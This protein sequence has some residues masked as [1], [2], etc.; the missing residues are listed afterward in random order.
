VSHA[1]EILRSVAARAAGR[2]G[3]HGHAAPPA[4]AEPA[5]GLQQATFGG[6]C[7][8]CTEA[9]FRRLKGVRAVTS[10]YSGGTEKNPTYALICSGTT[11]HAEVIQ[12]EFDPAQISYT[13]LLEVFWR[14]HDPTTRDRQ[15]ADV[16]PQYRSVIFYHT[17]EQKRT[18]EDL[19]RQLDAKGIFAA[20]IVTEVAPFSVFYP[21]ENYHQDYY[22]VNGRQPYCQVVIRPKL[23]KF[24]QVFKSKLK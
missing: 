12:V 22:A 23:E 24:E 6:G 15:G 17:Q 16:G 5:G 9:V 1:L 11:R 4:S 20:P 3:G 19:R 14:T 21:A 13:E 18:A 10:G 2:P 7:F 8:W